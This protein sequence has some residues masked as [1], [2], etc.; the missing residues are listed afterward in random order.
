MLTAGGMAVNWCTITSGSARAISRVCP[1]P[2][3]LIVVARIDAAPA[4]T[5]AAS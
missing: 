2:S 4:P 5:L 3:S 1:M